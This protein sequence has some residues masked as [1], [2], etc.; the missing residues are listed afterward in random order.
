MNIRELI[1]RIP[2]VKRAISSFR[3]QIKTQMVNVLKQDARN[4]ERELQIRALKDTVDFIETELP[5]ACSYPDRYALLEAALK[6]VT[7]DGV[8]IEFGVYQGNSINYLASKTN[9]KIHGFDSFEG[10]PEDWKD[11]YEKGVFSVG[12]LPKVKDNVSLIKGWFSNTLPDFMEKESENV[13][14]L[15]I[16]CDLYSSTKTIFDFLAERIVAGTVLVFD[17]YFN[18]PG[19]RNGEFKAFQEFCCNK[20]VKFEYIGYCRYSEQVA[21]RI[22]GIE[23]NNN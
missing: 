4:I 11:G 22:L 12:N 8:Y 6:K 19:W 5:L 18:Y 10:L 13:A 15:H 3:S 16:D 17:E 9:H 23:I 14:F 21:V 1:L 7:I 20:S 2:L